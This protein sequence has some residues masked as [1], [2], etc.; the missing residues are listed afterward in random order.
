VCFRF[1]DLIRLLVQGQSTQDLDLLALDLAT[2]HE[3]ASWGN[4]IR[5]SNLVP[6]LWLCM[7]AVFPHY[8]PPKAL[9]GRSTAETLQGGCDVM[10]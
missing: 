7:F 1:S 9:C 5:R 10:N 8:G 2:P 4:Q 3:I 6:S